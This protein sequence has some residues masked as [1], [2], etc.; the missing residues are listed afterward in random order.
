MLNLLLMQ[1]ECHLKITGGFKIARYSGFVSEVIFVDLNV[2]PMDVE[3]GSS[4][5]KFVKKKCEH[6]DFERLIP[7]LNTCTYSVQIT[8]SQAK[9][10]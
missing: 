5:S 7:T 4:T 1:L 9:M 3:K 8:V 2:S 10:Y 6:L